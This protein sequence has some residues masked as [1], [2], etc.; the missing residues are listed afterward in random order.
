MPELIRR[1]CGTCGKP[2]TA[3]EASIMLNH[4]SCDPVLQDLE[5]VPPPVEPPPT[6]VPPA[7]APIKVTGVPSPEVAHEVKQELSTI[8][9]W[10]EQHSPRSQQVNIGPSEL[11]TDCDRQLAYRVMGLTGPNDGMA[12]PWPAFVG[13]AI[14]TRIE[15]AIRKYERAHPHADPWNIEERVVADPLI[16][17]CAD[18][19]RKW[20]LV[21]IKSAGK[22]VMDKVRKNDISL[23]NIKQIMVYAKGLRDAGR[24]IT[25]VALVF[26]PRAGW[27]KDMHV[28]AAPYDEAIALAAIAR[29]YELAAKLQELDVVNHPHRWNLIDA[30]PSFACQWCPMYDRYVPAELGASDKGCPGYQTGKK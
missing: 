28:W 8:L 25:H 4:P 10:S 27:L 12:D 26:V 1:N 3:V 24:P 22:D 23:R 2:L 14:H 16:S 18:L 6:V 19:N 15:A 29:P 17:G 20:L 30:S 7:G 5:L 9:I 13:S 11:G 21:D